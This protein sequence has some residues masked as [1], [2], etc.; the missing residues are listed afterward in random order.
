MVA[1]KKEG[2]RKSCSSSLFLA[3]AVFIHR[4]GLC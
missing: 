4:S 3:E 1:Q 2:V